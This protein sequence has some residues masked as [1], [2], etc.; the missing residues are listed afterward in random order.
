MS[1]EAQ[2]KYRRQ[3]HIAKTCTH[4]KVIHGYAVA[5]GSNPTSNDTF[6]HVAEAR[7]TKPRKAPKRPTA[8]A[9]PPPAPRAAGL[10]PTSLALAA[11]RANFLL[12]GASNVVAWI[13]WLRGPG[14]RPDESAVTTFFAVPVAG[15]RLLV[16]AEYLLPYFL[17]RLFL[18]EREAPGVVWPRGIFE[19]WRDGLGSGPENIFAMDEVAAKTFLRELSG[20]IGGGGDPN[21]LGL[22][23]P[24]I[25][26]E[27]LFYAA[28]DRRDE[29]R[30]ARYLIAQFRDGL[31]L[32][33]RLPRSSPLDSRTWS[34]ERGFD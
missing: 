1:G 32:L 31:A 29:D 12:I 22:D 30:D 25:T 10:V 18:D 23:L 33:G 7:I 28:P 13:D 17:P 4:G 11:H 9:A 14:E 27:G 3:P 26:P 15:R 20:L 5:F 2:R 8:P 6:L 24:D 19:R 34:P 21:L 16:A